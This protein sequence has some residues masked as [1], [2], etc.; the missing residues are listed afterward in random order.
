M[1]GDHRGTLATIE[2]RPRSIFAKSTRVLVD[3]FDRSERVVACAPASGRQGVGRSLVVV[4]LTYPSDLVSELSIGPLDP[5][6]KARQHVSVR[7]TELPG[8][9]GAFDVQCGSTVGSCGVRKKT[10]GRAG[11]PDAGALLFKELSR[12]GWGSR[13][14]PPKT[15]G[16][17][18][19]WVSRTL[20]ATLGRQENCL[21]LTP[22]CRECAST[23]S[24]ARTI[25]AASRTSPSRLGKTAIL[26]NYSV[27]ASPTRKQKGATKKTAQ[28]PL[29]SKPIVRRLIGL[30]ALDGPSYARTSADPPVPSELP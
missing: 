12:F 28:L 16:R 24:Q 5:L 30:I 26:A 6:Q 17:A 7:T 21:A 9:W 22:R 3:I 18:P 14:T 25:D 23:R 29:T 15:P 10:R 19:A 1:P 20:G 8:R 11:A 13:V 2:N 4:S 27:Q